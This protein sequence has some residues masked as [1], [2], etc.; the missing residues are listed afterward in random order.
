MLGLVV[1]DALYHRFPTSNEG[2]KSKVKAAVVSTQ[3]LARQAE[4]IG[5]GQYL[6]LG[7]G[8][9]KTGGRAKP[10]LLADAF[11]ALIEIGRAHV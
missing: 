5:L 8:E 1:A 7:R 2:H 3:S 11:E 9:E 10:A 4:Q 6:L